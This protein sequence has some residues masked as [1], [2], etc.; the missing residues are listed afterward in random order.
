MPAP[1]V[2]T[3]TACVIVGPMRVRPPHDGDFAALAAITNHYIATTAVHFAYDAITEA[4]LRATWQR[5]GERFSWWV[6][7]RDGTIAGYAKSG[8][9]RERAAY[10]W[11]AE[12]GLYVADRERGQGIGRALYTALLD[13]LPRR[14]F[15]S[16]IAGITLPNDASIALHRAFGFT[17]V[18]V[19]EDAG[20]KHGRWHA[21]EFWQKRF[22]TD[23]ASPHGA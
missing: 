2:I 15:R 22:A 6:A 12:V 23:G 16:A 14:G 11:T 9:W 17:S 18:G 13:E 4:E 10:Q 3:S 21:V 5:Y 20:W 1:V 19:V 7:E 8:T